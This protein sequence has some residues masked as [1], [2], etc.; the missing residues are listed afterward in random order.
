MRPF[1]SKEEAYRAGYADANGVENAYNDG[2]DQGTEQGEQQRHETVI[3]F[4]VPRR[5]DASALL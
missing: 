5:E 3:A 2:Y 1:D 4:G